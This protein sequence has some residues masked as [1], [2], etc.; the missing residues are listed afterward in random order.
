MIIRP[1]TN[2]LRALHL[3]LVAS[4]S[5]CIGLGTPASSSA[6]PAGSPRL[7]GTVEGAPFSGAVFDEGSSGQTF[8]RLHEQLPDGSRIVK[9][10]RDSIVVKKT[11]GA[12]Y[13][14]FTTGEANSA[15]TAVPAQSIAPGRPR[16][17][18]SGSTPIPS[19]PR[20]RLGRTAEHE[21]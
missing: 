15:A 17:P 10:L 3:L 6:Q 5:L 2:T 4:A 21:E 14:I 13:E 7:V 8:Y 11:D 9:I 16:A 12:L 18:E 20:G 1:N 19:R